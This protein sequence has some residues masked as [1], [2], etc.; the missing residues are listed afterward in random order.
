MYFNTRL[1]NTN[2]EV[3][4]R[5]LYTESAQNIIQYPKKKQKWENLR[6]TC[7]KLFAVYIYAN[8][9]WS[10][11]CLCTLCNLSGNYFNR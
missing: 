8:D 3:R 2:K 10:T 11:S 6:Y 4:I 1:D 5:K 7:I 9:S